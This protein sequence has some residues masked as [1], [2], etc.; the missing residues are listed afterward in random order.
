MDPGALSTHERRLLRLQEE[1][2][3]LEKDALKEKDWHLQGEVGA[4][5][6]GMNSALEV[7]L[8]FETTVKT[9]LQPTEELTN[10]V[11]ELIKRRILN[12]EFDDVVRVEPGPL[13]KEKVVLQV[14][15]EKSKKGLG[16]LYADEYLRGT[17]F[18]P[19]NE[20][21]E[22]LRQEAGR[23]LQELFIKLDALS[24]FQFAPKPKVQELE[25]KSDVGAVVME[26][27]APLTVNTADMR[28][29]E[30]VF[31]AENNGVKKAAGEVTRE[32]RKRSR[33]KKKRLAKK[34]N[35]DKGPSGF[36]VGGP[37]V[38][39]AKR[40]KGAE[41]D[42]KSNFKSSTM[43]QKVQELADNKGAKGRKEVPGGSAPKANPYHLKL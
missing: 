34:K 7:D 15:E 37:A 20:K 4:S 32:E 30:E 40:A 22:K 9:L 41:G 18:D 33:A 16:E 28:R 23:L 13:P 26:E 11:E 21:K 25:V 3:Q 8:D 17:S 31:V 10:T 35:K 2:D 1:V 24:H 27:V 5:G 38:Q 29:P 43:F 39:S 36:L 42:Q 14:D 12:R 19:V 6:R